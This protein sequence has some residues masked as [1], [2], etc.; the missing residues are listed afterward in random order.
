MNIFNLKRWNFEMRTSIKRKFGSD[1]TNVADW[2]VFMNLMDCIKNNENKSSTGQIDLPSLIV[3][4]PQ[5]SCYF[6]AQSWSL[7]M[8]KSLVI[9]EILY[10]L[11]AAHRKPKTQNFSLAS[12]TCVRCRYGIKFDQ[13]MRAKNWNKTWISSNKT[14]S[15]HKP[16]LTKI[17]LSLKLKKEKWK[18][19]RYLEP[20]H[21]AH[22]K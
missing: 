6:K 2:G 11:S 14:F 22:L 21:S 8:S 17:N 5:L 18:F 3:C 15:F 4:K 19:F 7:T 9:V 12:S 1:W 20:E 13:H 16:K 10:F